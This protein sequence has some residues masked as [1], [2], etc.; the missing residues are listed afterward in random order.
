LKKSEAEREEE[1]EEKRAVEMKVFDLKKEV[2]DYFD[3]PILL[4]AW[5]M[6][7]PIH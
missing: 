7:N 6:V 3:S 4:R 2:F 1:K 5:L